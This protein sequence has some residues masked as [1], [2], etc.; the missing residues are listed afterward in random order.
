MLSHPQEPVS[1]VAYSAFASDDDGNAS[2]TDDL[3]A[4]AGWTA[5]ARTEPNSGGRFEIVEEGDVD[6]EEEALAL[7]ERLSAKYGDVPIE[8]I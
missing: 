1:S 2:Y 7:A 3:A 4:A 5:Y 8:R 6:T